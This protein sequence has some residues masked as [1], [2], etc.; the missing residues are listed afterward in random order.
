[1]FQSI[2]NGF[3]YFAAGFAAGDIWEI[4]YWKL[5]QVDSSHTD[6]SVQGRATPVYFLYGFNRP[7][8]FYVMIT[9]FP[10]YG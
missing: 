7:R 10:E 8:I 5:N 9:N 4:P 1:M 2:F 6:R 3:T